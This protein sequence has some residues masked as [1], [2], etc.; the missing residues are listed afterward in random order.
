[1]EKQRIRITK[2]TLKKNKVKKL[3]L[4]DVQTYYKAD[5]IKTVWC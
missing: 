2:I 5:I 3:I 4:S 1:M